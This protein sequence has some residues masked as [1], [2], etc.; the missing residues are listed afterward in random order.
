VILDWVPAHFPRDDFSLRRFDG[1]ALYEHEDPRLGEHPDWGTLIF[2]Y[3]RAEVKNFLVANALYWLKEFHIDALRVDAVASILYL[4]YSRKADQWVPNSYGGRENIDAIGFLRDFNRAIR[5]DVPGAFTIAEESTAWGGVTRSPDEGGLG[6]TF[7]WNMGWMHDTL[8]YFQKDPVHRKYH[9]NDLTFAMLYE[10]TE[11]FVNAISHDEVVHGKGALIDKLP[12]DLWQKFANLRLLLG[13]QFTRPGK[14]LVFMGT[15][16][17]QWREWNHD[18]SLDFHLQEDP[19]R[20]SLGRYITRLNK[21]YAETPAF[22]QADPNP[23]SF[24]WIDCADAENSILSYVRRSGRRYVVVVMNLT[25]VPRPAYRLGAP[26][27]VTYVQKL[28]SDAD[29]FGGSGYAT[30]S[31]VVA[32]PIPMHGRSHSLELNLPPLGI[33]VLEPAS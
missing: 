13:Y 26:E 2:N 14:H 21:L 17:A 31:E 33:L 32:E 22:W 20:Q 12:G 3:G 5:A 1:T 7:K 29:E 11:R 10:F 6:F 15:E 24:E 23:E 25:P 18:E 28:N 8:Q 16:I 4:D 9:Q 19:E 27:A 30:R